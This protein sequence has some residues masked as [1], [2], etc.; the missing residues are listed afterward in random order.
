MTDAVYKEIKKDLV[1]INPAY[2][3]CIE[4]GIRPVYKNSADKYIPIQKMLT[5]MKEYSNRLELPRGYSYRLSEILEQKIELEYLDCTD[6]RRLIDNKLNTDLFDYQTEAVDRLISKPCGILSSPAASGKTV[7][8]IDIVAKLG[9]KTLWLVH[10]DRLMKQAIETLLKFTDCNKSDIGI[11]SQG[12]Y[13]IGN[14]FTSAI[15]DT[16]RKYSKQLSKEKFGL[17]IVDEVH[18]APTKKTYDVLMKLS[19]Q[20]LYGLS[21]TPYRTDGLDDIM[22]YM[23]GPITEIERC[24]V[25]E[26]DRII[27]PEIKII[28]TNLLIKTES[29]LNSSYSDF[30]LALISNE[31]R[32]NKILYEII[33]EVINA[34][35]CLVLSDRVSHGKLLYS[36][37]SRIYPYIEIVNGRTNKKE[38]DKIIKKLEERKITVLISTYQFL[39]EGVDLPIINRMF[40]AT[41]FRAPIRA[42]QAVG[43][44]QRTYMENKIAK[45]YDFVDSNSLTLKQLDSR[46]KVY[47]K[48][49]CNVTFKKSDI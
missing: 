39:S 25:V 46:I 44:V 28:Y 43:R 27:T 11:I 8:G 40:F 15:V 24:C 41:P 35:V 33:K 3:S 18:R 32:N 45:I 36:K 29:V 2:L 7:I 12:K 20:Y 16:A 5:F 30:M 22:K 4:R 14:V 26:T 19:P 21:A 23:I 49:G 1:V 13:E 47:K 34:N 31:D 10:L 17:V 48:L 6:V 37:L 9:L 42:E 38:A